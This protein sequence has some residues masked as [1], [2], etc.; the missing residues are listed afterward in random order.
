[1]SKIKLICLAVLIIAGCSNPRKDPLRNFIGSYRDYQKTTGKIKN[2]RYYS[3]NDI[4]SFKAP[5]LASPGAIIE[6]NLK[7]NFGKTDPVNSAGTISFTDDFGNFLRVDV[8][9][10]PEDPMIR[11]LDDRSLLSGIREFMMTI[12]R[13]LSSDTEL[14]HQEYFDFRDGRA[15]YFI[16]HI[17][18]GSTFTINGSRADVSRASI[19]FIDGD[20]VYVFSTQYSDMSPFGPKSLTDAE[21]VEKLKND[22]MKTVN[23]FESVK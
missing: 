16:A 17:K 13:E 9:G 19:S 8:F 14:T 10:I 4:F 18:R 15:D 6:D 12:Y 21:I 2:G 23:T 20:Y 7:K 1:M 3:P 5:R 22:L 11:L